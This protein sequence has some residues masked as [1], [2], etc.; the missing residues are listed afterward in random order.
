MKIFNDEKYNFLDSMIEY[1]R[2]D[3]NMYDML[4]G[5]SYY[6]GPKKSILRNKKPKLKFVDMVL[7]LKNFVKFDIYN[8]WHCDLND[9]FTPFTLA[10]IIKSKDSESNLTKI[11]F[12]NFLP[13]NDEIPLISC[14]CEEAYIDIK[15][16]I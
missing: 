11:V 10:H 2:L 1:I 8:A 16:K 3:D 6:A 5:I 4:I 13:E 14:L 12:V 7:R 9:R 15:G